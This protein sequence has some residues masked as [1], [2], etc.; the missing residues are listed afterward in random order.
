M[1][2]DNLTPKQRTEWQRLLAENTRLKETLA[3]LISAHDTQSVAILTRPEFIREIARLVAHDDR[4]GGTSSLLVLSFEGLEN[5]K[6]Q[7]G[8]YNY[9]RVLETISNCVSKLSRAC[10]V[11]G[12]TGEEDF[13]IMLTRCNIE[14]AEKKAEVI[15]SA[16]KERLDPMLKDKA[17]VEL[18]YTVSIL[19]KREAA[20]LKQ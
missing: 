13:S 4:Y 18:K 19:T 11:A 14:N 20:S 3:D 6:P 10:D 2:L 5:Q 12:R 8:P 1:N 16:L 17:A 9:D 7:L 15:V